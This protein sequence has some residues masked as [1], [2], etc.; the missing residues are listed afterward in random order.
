LC[1]A[2]TTRISREHAIVAKAANAYLSTRLEP[3]ANL[4]H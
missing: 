3:A 2:Q 1:A 4:L